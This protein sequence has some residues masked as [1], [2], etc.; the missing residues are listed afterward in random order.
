[1]FLEKVVVFGKMQKALRSEDKINL[2]EIVLKFVFI[3]E[4]FIETVL[5]EGE[6]SIK[7]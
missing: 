3:K 4:L 7:L 6:R 1:M 5:R 2:V